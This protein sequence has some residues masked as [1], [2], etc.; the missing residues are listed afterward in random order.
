[1]GNKWT[2]AGGGMLMGGLVARQLGLS[3]PL[4]W[5]LP[6]LGGVAGYRY[7]PKAMNHFKDPLGKGANAV[8]QAQQAGYQQAFTS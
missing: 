6:I 4:A 3:G 5:L 8:P 7:L 1:M 2:G